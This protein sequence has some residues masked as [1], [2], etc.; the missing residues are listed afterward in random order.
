M[1]DDKQPPRVPL[2]VVD[3]AGATPAW[4]PWL[5]LSLLCLSL[6]V[7]AVREATG[8]GSE[9]EAA[10]AGADAGTDEAAATDEHAGEPPAAA[11]DKP[12]QVPSPRAA[13]NPD[14][15]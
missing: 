14:K 1:S 10:A 5:G 2:V 7:I 4:I 8:W 9:P 15:H 11:A 3:E 12:I 13:G 6:L